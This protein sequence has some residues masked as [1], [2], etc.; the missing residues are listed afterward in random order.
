MRLDHQ[1]D[2]VHSHQWL[3]LVTVMVMVVIAML[4]IEIIFVMWAVCIVIVKA[5][6]FVL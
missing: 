2:A 5:G 6:G 4:M 1:G 3:L